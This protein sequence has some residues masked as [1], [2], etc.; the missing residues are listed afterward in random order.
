M[1]AKLNRL[2]PFL[3]VAVVLA[4]VAAGAVLFGAGKKAEPGSNRTAP[5]KLI[6]TVTASGQVTLTAPNGHPVTRLPS[7]WYTV[8]VR[9][10]SSNADFHLTGPT[11]RQTTRTHFT[12]EA[13]WGVHFIVGTYRYENAHSGSSHATMHLISVY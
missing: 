10:N 5:P 11:V 8:L 13:L 7:G 2:W 1:R 4:L 12:G 6:A 9:V 3:A